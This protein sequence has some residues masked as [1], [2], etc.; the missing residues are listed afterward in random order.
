MVKSLFAIK[1]TEI[2]QNNEI[3]SKY[4]KHKEIKQNIDN[5]LTEIEIKIGIKI[6]RMAVN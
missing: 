4:L 6:K 2:T 5:S 1:Q 3:A